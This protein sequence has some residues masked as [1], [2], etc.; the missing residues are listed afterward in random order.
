M[1]ATLPLG[2][3]TTDHHRRHSGLGLRLCALM[4]D[5]LACIGAPPHDRYIDTPGERRFASEEQLQDSGRAVP[6]GR[7]GQAEDI[8]NSVSFLCRCVVR[9]WG[10]LHLARVCGAW[11]HTLPNLVVRASSR[12]TTACCGC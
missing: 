2:T 4:T 5:G 10:V 1:A 9:V 6:I 11:C 8:A 3:T 7:I 12:D